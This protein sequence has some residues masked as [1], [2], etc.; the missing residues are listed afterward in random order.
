MFQIDDELITAS[1]LRASTVQVFAERQVTE[2][3]FTAT[4]LASHLRQPVSTV[5]FSLRTLVRLYPR[6]TRALD[7]F[8]VIWRFDV[9]RDF[10]RQLSH[11][12]ITSLPLRLSLT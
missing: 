2:L 5:G 1:V 6:E 3:I 11:R 12:N 4:K 8:A 9:R 10:Q 7:V